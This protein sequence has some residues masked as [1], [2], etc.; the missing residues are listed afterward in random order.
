[1]LLF[2]SNRSNI[3]FERYPIVSMHVVPFQHYATASAQHQSSEWMGQ[4]SV[5]HSFRGM[6]KLN[7][8]IMKHHASYEHVYV[9]L[10]LSDRINVAFTDEG[11]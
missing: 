8:P 11:I 1:M 6:C 9:K 5:V 2:S 3:L 10:P 7:R 4:R